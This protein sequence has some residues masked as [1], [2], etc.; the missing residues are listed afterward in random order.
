MDRQDF[1]G[2]YESYMGVYEQDEYFEEDV[3]EIDEA[4]VDTEA[5]RGIKHPMDK[6]I[7]KKS[8]RDERNRP[9]R[10]HYTPTQWRLAAARDRWERDN[11]EHSSEGER[12]A[13]ESRHESYEYDLYDLVLEYLLDEGLCES[14][15]NAEIMMAHMSE[16]WVD[17]IVESYELDEATIMSVSRGGKPVYQRAKYSPGE[18]ENIRKTAIRQVVSGVGENESLG[19]RA[20]RLMQQHGSDYFHYLRPTRAEARKKRERDEARYEEGRR[21]HPTNIMNAKP[22]ESDGYGHDD[23][24]PDAEYHY[25][26]A[27]RE[28]HLAHVR[29]KAKARKGR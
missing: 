24:G 27:D 5:T 17:A 22:G 6:I 3:E 8:M 20:K 29:T 9:S 25:S 28:T 7:A 16:E 15:E 12:K 1:M 18:S 2:L 11:E 10:R 19:N 23:E 21:K 13:G 14:V 26:K 4:R